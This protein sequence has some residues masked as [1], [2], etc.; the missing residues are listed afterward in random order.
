MFDYDVAIAVMRECPAVCRD[1][2]P[3][4]AERWRSHLTTLITDI[5]ADVEVVLSRSDVGIWRNT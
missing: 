5:D 1:W 2:P 4:K 3:D